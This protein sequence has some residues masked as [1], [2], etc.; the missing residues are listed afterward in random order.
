MK[1]FKSLLILVLLI[2]SQTTWAEFTSQEELISSIHRAGFNQVITM[3]ANELSGF[4]IYMDG[5]SSALSINH[6]V[7]RFGAERLPRLD[8]QGRS[9]VPSSMDAYV[10]ADSV[11][12]YVN[13]NVINRTFQRYHFSHC[14]LIPVPITQVINALDRLEDQGVM[15]LDENN[16]GYGSESRN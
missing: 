4:K 14:M 15:D 11:V 2:G 6:Y 16:E 13:N 12:C 9:L 5:Q 1:A 10:I 7:S 8:I 3:G